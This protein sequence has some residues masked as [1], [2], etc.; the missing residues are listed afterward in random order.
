MQRAALISAV[1]CKP[2]AALPRFAINNRFH[3][4]RYDYFVSCSLAN[5]P[6]YERTESRTN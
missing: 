5:H 1:L 4:F 2:C 6:D 3:F